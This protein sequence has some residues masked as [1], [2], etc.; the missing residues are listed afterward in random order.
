M[1][2][3]KTQYRQAKEILKKGILRRHEQWQ[4]GL[5]EMLARPYDDEIGNAYD[6]S[7][8]IM[9]A[10]RNWNK[11]ADKMEH[12]YDKTYILFAIGWLHDEGFISQAEFDM[13]V[14]AKG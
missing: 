6:R 13:V 2:L 9:K 8:M 3:S 12:W 10:V 1:E 11:E 14:S 5:A 7:I 4:I